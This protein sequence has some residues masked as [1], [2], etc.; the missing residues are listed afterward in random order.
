MSVSGSTGRGGAT[1]ADGVAPELRGGLASAVEQLGHDV[2][3]HDLYDAV[4][5]AIYDD[6]ASLDSSEIRELSRLVRAT[7]GR[8]LELAAG[9][10]RL[11]L[12]L[13][14]LKRDVTAVELSTAMIA[15]LEAKVGQLPQATASR[16]LVLEGDMSDVELPGTFGVVV[17][18]TASISLLGPD[19]R[20]RLFDRVRAH[21]DQDGVLLLCV[22]DLVPALA[23]EPAWDE[24][25]DLVGA[26]GARYRIHYFWQPGE[27]RRHVGV[28]PL[29]V[30]DRAIPVCTSTPAII[31]VALI[32]HELA[33]AGLRVAGRHPVSGG[34]KGFREYFLEVRT[35]HEHA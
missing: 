4:G 26:S 25:A 3:F 22:A 20:A 12:P 15:L 21:L 2:E 28:Y 30:G 5:A 9:S 32:E 7:P 24:H 1:L 34:W 6:T 33:Q 19:A 23:H 11:T 29:D 8:V 27:D 31:D 18:G 13:L 10:G 35:A 14:R 16:L 17:L